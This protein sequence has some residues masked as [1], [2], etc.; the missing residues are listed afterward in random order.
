MSTD[1]VWLS[2]KHLPPTFLPTIYK[3]ENSIGSE[4]H[5]ALLSDAYYLLGD[6]HDFNEAPLAAIKAYKKSIEVYDNGYSWRELGG[7]YGNIGEIEKALSC[8]R[9]AIDLEPDDKYTQM[10]LRFFEETD[11]T[12][13]YDDGD[14]YWEAR[15]FLAVNQY[16][17]F[18]GV[19]APKKG[20]KKVLYKCLALGAQNKEDQYVQCIGQLQNFEKKFR[21]AWCNWFYRPANIE[22]N[23]LYWQILIS[24]YPRLKS[25]VG[26]SHDSL[27]ENYIFSFKNQDKL[28]EGM[29]PE[30]VRLMFQYNLYRC[31][32]DI[33]KLQELSVHYPLWK[34][35]KCEMK[36]LKRRLDQGDVTCEQ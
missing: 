18:Y 9:K 32:G 17:K 26:L 4:K 1:C 21:F 6:I 8:L 29:E 5:A 20:L 2:C 19:I 12:R 23:A 28:R 10:D 22:E 7:M 24:L 13:I 36:S 30:H 15:E 25:G 16:E 14:P 34:E 31:Q 27:A 35:L 11:D 33:G 3:A